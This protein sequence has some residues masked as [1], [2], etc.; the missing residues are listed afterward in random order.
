M[1]IEIDV[2]PVIP[3]LPTPIVSISE[4]CS[5]TCECLLASAICNIKFSNYPKEVEGQ[6][7]LDQLESKLQECIAGHIAE[8]G[9]P[10]VE[11][12]IE[13]RRQCPLY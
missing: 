1:H 8:L 10:R 3:P 13:K 5:C 4:P 9:R 7:K 12:E 2:T 6:M 11:Q